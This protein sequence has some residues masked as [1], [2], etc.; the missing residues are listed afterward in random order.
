MSAFPYT[1]GPQVL[2]PL[3]TSNAITK[4]GGVVI[5]YASEIK[6]G[7][8]DPSLR[9]VFD[10]AFARAGSDPRQLVISHTRD[11][12]AIVPGIPMDFNAALNMTLLYVSRNRMILVSDDADAEQAAQIGFEYTNSIQRAVEKVALDL[13][14]ATVNILPLGG[15]VMPIVPAHMRTK[16]L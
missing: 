14:E 1:D 15:I 9:Q 6:G 16:W 11:H 12:R 2:K 10:T 3:A 13:P 4:K 7:G 8:F 5:L